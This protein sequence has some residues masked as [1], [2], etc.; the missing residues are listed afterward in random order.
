MLVYSSIFIMEGIHWADVRAFLCGGRATRDQGHEDIL[1]TLPPTLRTVLTCIQNETLIPQ[2]TWIKPRL[3]KCEELL[4]KGAEPY[5][6]V[7]PG[8]YSAD[9]VLKVMLWLRMAVLK[10]CADIGARR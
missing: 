8:D 4:G 6:A 7:L 1:E 3:D 2:P 5:D 10:T 9:D